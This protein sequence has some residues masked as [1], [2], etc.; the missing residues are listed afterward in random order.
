MS[1]CNCMQTQKPLKFIVDSMTEDRKVCFVHPDSVDISS[2]LR[3][4]A[5]NLNYYNRE[6]TA[7]Y[8]TSAFMG[9]GHGQFID[10]ETKLRDG[11]KMFECNRILSEIQYDT[12][13][14]AFLNCNLQ[15]DTSLRPQSTRSNLRNL[16]ASEPTCKN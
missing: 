12:N 11:Q 8:G 3:G 2:E 13:D 5:T 4:T 6:Q 7:L 14:N 16:Y 15:V 9:R 1:N 10:T